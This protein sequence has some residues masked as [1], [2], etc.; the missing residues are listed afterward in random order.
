MVKISIGNY[1]EKDVDKVLA[2]F[3]NKYERLCSENMDCELPKEL[4]FI[5]MGNGD[6][7]TIYIK[8]PVQVL[9]KFEGFFKGE[10]F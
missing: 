8:V 4:E 1:K 3:Q 2:N 10:F 9:E 6:F 5:T 7:E